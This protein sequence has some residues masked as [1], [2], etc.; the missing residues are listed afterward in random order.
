MLLLVT[1]TIHVWAAGMVAKKNL[2]VCRVT[3]DTRNLSSGYGTGI[4]ELGKFA[5]YDI[6]E[7]TRKAFRDERDKQIFIVDV[8]IE[9]GDYKDLEKGKPARVMLSMLAR[10]AENESNKSIL[11]VE[12]WTTYG[13]K[14][15]TVSVSTQVVTEDIVQHFALTCS[16]DVS[17][18]GVKRGEVKWLTKTKAKKDN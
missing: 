17:K 15:G 7:V 18:F 11:P 12:A 16:D 14:W 8:E 6:E 10:H 4:Y 13:R 1:A 2:D 9:Y 5:V 3:T